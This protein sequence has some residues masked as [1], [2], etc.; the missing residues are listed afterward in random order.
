MRDSLEIE[1]IRAQVTKLL[2]LDDE[3]QADSVKLRRQARHAPFI[4]AA[5]FIGMSVAMGKIL[6]GA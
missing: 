5:T 4:A 3:L 1:Q 6:F 2:A